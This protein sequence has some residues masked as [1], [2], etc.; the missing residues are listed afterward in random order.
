MSFGHTPTCVV[1]NHLNFDDKRIKPRRGTEIDVHKI[2]ATFTDLGFGFDVHHDKSE[3]E[4]KAEIQR[5]EK[6]S[7][8]L[9]TDGVYPWVCCGG[10]STRI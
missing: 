7:I 6:N 8:H 5:C 9:Y 4:I 3:I 2:E 10:A 1:F